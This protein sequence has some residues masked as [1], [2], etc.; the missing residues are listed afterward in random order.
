MI[1]LQSG[2][3][4]MNGL[5]GISVWVTRLGIQESTF[6]PQVN[7]NLFLCVYVIYICLTSVD[8]FSLYLSRG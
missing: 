8:V 4:S 7:S 6:F 5:G 1:I 3:M 2:L